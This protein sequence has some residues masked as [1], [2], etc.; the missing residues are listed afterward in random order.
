M[1]C[2]PLLEA[3]SNDVSCLCSN[4]KDDREKLNLALGLILVKG[5]CREQALIMNMKCFLC[6]AGIF[7]N[8]VDVNVADRRGEKEKKNQHEMNSG[9]TFSY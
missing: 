1:V 6:T 7:F 9:K 4:W 3:T 5:R 8:I 2:T